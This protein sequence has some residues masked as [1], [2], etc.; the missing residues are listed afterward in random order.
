MKMQN[1]GRNYDPYDKKQAIK[2]GAHYGRKANSVAG[3]S[4]YG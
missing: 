2:T 3:L 1:G 4:K